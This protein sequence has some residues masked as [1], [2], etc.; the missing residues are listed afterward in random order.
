V[1]LH[2]GVDAD[3]INAGLP[4]E[5]GDEIVLWD[6]N[7]PTNGVAWDVRAGRF[8]YAVKRVSTAANPKSPDQLRDAFLGAFTPRTRV[9]AL[10]HVSSVTGV[11]LPVQEICQEARRRGI[12][13]HVDG[14]QTWGALRLNLKMMGCDSF[15]ASAH[16]W[17]MGPKEAPAQ[18]TDSRILARSR[19]R[20]SICP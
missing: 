8:G 20:F 13:S 6:Q 9:V 2:L 3:L 7:H 14:A 1:A 16:K 10:T 4:L 19:V 5:A 15:A 17:P 18:I 11:R 12:Y